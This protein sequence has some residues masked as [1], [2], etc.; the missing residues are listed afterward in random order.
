MSTPIKVKHIQQHEQPGGF[1]LLNLTLENDAPIQA[2]GLS[3]RYELHCDNHSDTP[4]EG[5]LF[6]TSGKRLQLLSKRSLASSRI[7][8]QSE[9]ACSNYTLIPH[10][11]DSL[12]QALSQITLQQ[13]T[14]LL[15]KDLNIAALLFLARMR[16]SIKA[17]TLAFLYASEAFPFAVKP[18]RFMLPESPPEAIGACPLLEDWN[19]ANRLAC[20]ALLPGCYQGSLE[21]LVNY[22]REQQSGQDSWQVIDLK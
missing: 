14:L 1:W 5:A 4:I 19:I 18:A 6:Q 2:N 3:H 12:Q 17:P 20:Q 13:P 11:T 8:E 9:Q 22:W 15:A 16:Q 10:Q 21:E 7:E